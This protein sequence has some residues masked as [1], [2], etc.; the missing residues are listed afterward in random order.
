MVSRL[1]D[2]PWGHC[3]PC[4]RD[5]L[6][7]EGAVTGTQVLA[8][9]TSQFMANQPCKGSGLKPSKPRPELTPAQE[10]ALV[11]PD[12]VDYTAEGD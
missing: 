7:E 9:H 8:H 2:W 1:D 3:R 4:R 10:A 11:P 5:V 6:T 12:E